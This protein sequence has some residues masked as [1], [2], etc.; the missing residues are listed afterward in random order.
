MSRNSSV[1]K[2]LK[3]IKFIINIIWLV[4][5][6]PK[7]SLLRELEC[8]FKMINVVQHLF[9]KMHSLCFSTVEVYLDV[10]V[11]AWHY[12]PISCLFDQTTHYIYIG[13]FFFFFHLL[14]QP[15]NGNPEACKT[16]FT[17]FLSLQA[18]SLFIPPMSFKLACLFHRPI[19]SGLGQKPAA[20]SYRER[21]H[22]N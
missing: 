11:L 9:V 8:V 14:F 22:I 18:T 20:D 16:Q 12:Q 1:L 21:N 4:Y 2:I 7:T 15:W 17:S 5:I 19:L 6:L 3:Q 13:F 10:G